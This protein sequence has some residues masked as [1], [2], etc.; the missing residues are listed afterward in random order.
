MK[1][2][3]MQIM[4]RIYSIL[5]T[6]FIFQG[7]L[8]AQPDPGMNGDSTLVGGGPLSGGVPLGSGLFFFLLFGIG[9]GIRKWLSTR[10]KDQ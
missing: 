6:W 1:K 10:R 8:F 7:G 2:G 4:I 3:Y 5:N 9:Y